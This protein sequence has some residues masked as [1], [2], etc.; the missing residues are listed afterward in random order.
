MAFPNVKDERY[1]VLCEGFQINNEELYLFE[2]DELQRSDCA[3]FSGNRLGVVQK[4]NT[5]HLDGVM[6]AK[7]TYQSLH[8]DAFE[9]LQTGS[10][11]NIETY[12]RNAER[13]TG[14]LVPKS[15]LFLDMSSAAVVHTDS[16]P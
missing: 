6:A 10:L 14:M 5:G 1:Y 13:L 9:M 2:P 8:T 11:T 7:V 12:G 15:K 3:I 4:A 16:V